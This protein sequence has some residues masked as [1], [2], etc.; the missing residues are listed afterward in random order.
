MHRALF[1]GMDSLSVVLVLTQFSHL[2]TCSSQKLQNVLR[3]QYLGRK[4]LIR[5]AWALF[6]SPGEKNVLQ[7]FSPCCSKVQSPGWAAF[8]SLL[9]VVHV[10]HTLMKLPLSQIVPLSPGRNCRLGV[11]GFCFP[12]LSACNKSAYCMDVVFTPDSDSLVMV[13]GESLLHLQRLVLQQ[14][15]VLCINFCFI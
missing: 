12:F 7:C 4:G 1:P 10:S 8:W 9:T 11:L 3:M 5:T 14:I 13:H 15:Y 6:Q 2:L